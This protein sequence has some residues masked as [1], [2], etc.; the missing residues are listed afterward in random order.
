VSATYGSSIDLAITGIGMVSP[1]GLDAQTGCAA[2]RAGLSRAAA[3][4]SFKIYSK[5]AWSHVGVTGHA[6]REFAGGFEGFGRFVRLGSGALADLL[7][8]PGDPRGGDWSRTALCVSLPSGYLRGEQERDPA[9]NLADNGSATA[10]SAAL[11]DSLLAR[12][13]ELASIAIPVA[14]HVSI[15]EDQA[16]F[17]RSLLRAWH[18]V[19]TG[20]ADRCIVGGIDACTDE[21]HL[22]AAHHFNILKTEDQPSGFQP[23]EGAA[24]LM[25]ESSAAAA[26]RGAQITGRIETVAIGKEATA[27]CARKPA[28]GIGLAETIGCCLE[29]LTPQ[30][31]VGW[32]LADLNGDAF[33][34]NDWGYALVRL[35]AAHPELGGC[36]VVIPAESFGETGAAQ[37]ALAACMAVRAFAR[38]YSPAPRALI[39]LASYSGERGAF[40]IAAQN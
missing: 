18:L 29:S 7:R 9:A 39:W 23:G 32:I 25:L 8:G 33:R 17:A 6:V 27:R 26:A 36:Q 2:A 15:F 22:A 30:G 11:A 13:C 35:V 3:L 40:T 21:A 14:N 31:A 12:L 20:V 10:M 34:A 24:F 37:G 28:L 5:G 4:D 38:K 1:L 16:G 19:S